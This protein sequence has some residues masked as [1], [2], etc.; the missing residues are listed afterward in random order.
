MM[1]RAICCTCGHHFEIE[2]QAV[3][4]SDGYVDCPDCVL[5]QA[6]GAPNSVD[7]TVSAA[8]PCH[9]SATRHSGSGTVTGDDSQQT[10]RK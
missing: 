4:D 1:I 8:V 10:L 7:T 5:G 9:E 2:D 6:R 3:R